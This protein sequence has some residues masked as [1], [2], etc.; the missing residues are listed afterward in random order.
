MCGFESRSGHCGN[1]AAGKRKKG[2]KLMYLTKGTF[3]SN[4]H[5]YE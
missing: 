5:S 4:Q 1:E 2:R 3:I